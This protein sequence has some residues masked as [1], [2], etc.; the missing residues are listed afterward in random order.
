EAAATDAAGDRRADG[1]VPE[2]QLGRLDGRV[3]GVDLGLGR[4]DVGLLH[5]L[6]LLDDGATGVDLRRG[7]LVARRCRVEL[8]LGHGPLTG[9]RLDARQVLLR[10]EELGL[11]GDKVGLRAYE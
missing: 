1:R 6:G 10:V 8:R 3:G 2:V 5:Q 4:V 9:E 11:V 7:L